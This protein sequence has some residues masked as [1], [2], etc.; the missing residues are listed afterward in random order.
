MTRIASC[1]CGQLELTCTGESHRVSICFC[2]ACQKRTGSAF[3]VQARFREDQ[4]AI[5]GA[6]TEFVRVGDEGG[7]ITFRFCPT[8]G[9]S[10]YYT[11]DYMD[12]AIAIAVGAFADPSFP[13]PTISVYEHRRHA[14]V[15]VPESVVEHLD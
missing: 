13:G 4:V 9:T 14:W 8:C 11:A 2:L 5:R 7:R 1:S 12:G 3:G 15:N 6:A 10:V